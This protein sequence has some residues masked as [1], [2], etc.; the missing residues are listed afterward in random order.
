MQAA[1]SELDRFFADAAGRATVGTA[2]PDGSI[3]RFE[4]HGD[5]GGSWTLVRQGARVEFAE[6]PHPAP[7]C[8]LRCSADDFRL[9]ID[10]TLDPREGYLSGRLVLQG[11]VGIVLD[12]RRAMRGRRR[13]AGR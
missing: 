5:G 2:L 7:D 12:L 4:L 3:V 9:L 1:D 11:D 13:I 10:G 6:P 8:H